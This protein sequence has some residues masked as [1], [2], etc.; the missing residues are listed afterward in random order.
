[1]T[2]RSLLAVLAVACAA[3][4]VGPAAVAADSG[5]RPAALTP[6]AIDSYLHGYLDRT[7]LPGATVAVTREGEVVHTAGYGRSAAG[8]DLTAHTPMP[9]ASLSK[10]M[11]AMAV[12]RL[13]EE[14]EVALDEPVRQYVP[15]F[16]MA[17]ERAGR[18][19][20]RQLLN[21]TSGMADSAHPDLRRPQPH[22]LREAVAALGSARLATEPGTTW[23]YHNPNYAVAA[24][25]VESVSGR[26]YADYLSDE[27]FTPLGMA[28]ARS[29]D[30]TDDMP[31]HARGHVRAY[32]QVFAADHPR[33]FVAGAF[34]V[35]AS[36]DDLAQWLIAQRDG[37]GVLS[38][39]GL[40]T[41][42]TPPDGE[43]Y[44]MGWSDARE[45]DGPP[46]LQHS[47]QLL[48]HNALQ[49]LLPE[50]GISLAVVTNTGM[51]S[52]DDAAVITDGLIGLAHGR[53]PGTGEPFSMTADY[54]LAA[55]TL[56]ALG[57]AVRGALR[58]RRWAA[59]A[60]ARPRWRTALRLLPYTLGPALLYGLTDL[61]GLLMNRAG[62]LGQLLYVW[63]AL[64]IWAAATALACTVLLLARA[65]AWLTAREPASA[66]RAFLPV[67]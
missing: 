29:V 41:L 26:P 62:T 65:L 18:I 60:A 9:I 38:P 34:G 56:L 1:M 13:V 45:G 22:T 66:P 51:V 5:P 14:G 2:S 3:L 24:R 50:Q 17:D 30:T 63:P 36:A 20:V 52:G 25:L 57:L 37:G 48:T 31:D 58:A 44:A 27:V 28:D 8:E 10:S 7:G 59:R 54:L 11:T 43:R 55:L 15:E 35:L 64:V 53:D 46:V 6:T 49:T 40:D 42:H 33:W 4:A 19:T 16:T 47:G 21:Q 12:L 67:T 32:G 61:A 39:A 23:N